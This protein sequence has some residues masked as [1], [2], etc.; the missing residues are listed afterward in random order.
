MKPRPHLLW[1]CLLK[2]KPFSRNGLFWFFTLSSRTASPLPGC[3]QALH[4]TWGCRDLKLGVAQGPGHNKSSN[5]LPSL[6]LWE[7]PVLITQSKPIC[8]PFSVL[9]S[10]QAFPSVPIT[11]PV[12]SQILP[13]PSTIFQLLSHSPHLF[14]RQNTGRRKSRNR[15]QKQKKQKQQSRGWEW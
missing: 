2:R 13:F 5:L 14:L 11:S 9:F 12:T 8:S 15:K 4:P 7:A 10:S 3:T 6:I 1:Y